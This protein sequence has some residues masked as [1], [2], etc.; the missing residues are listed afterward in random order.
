MVVSLMDK[1]ADLTQK[2]FET[3]VLAMKIKAINF[4]NFQSFASVRENLKA[5]E[6]YPITGI[7][8]TVITE[9]KEDSVS[10]V[11]IVKNGAVWQKHWQD[12]D[13]YLKIVQGVY[14]DLFTGKEYKEKLFVKAFDPSYFQSVGSEDLVL[15]GKVIKKINN[16]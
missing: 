16:E 6:V 11:A 9:S 8:Y 12:V 14:L 7:G 4:L 5:G 15:K 2:I 13:K 1:I 3:E 10:F